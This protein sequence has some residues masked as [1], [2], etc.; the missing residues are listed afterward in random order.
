[1]KKY[2]EGQIIYNNTQNVTKLYYENIYTSA[3]KKDEAV[4]RNIVS[5]NC[6]SIANNP[7]KL[8]VYY[9]NPR[10]F[11][12]IAHNNMSWSDDKLLR[13]SVVYKYTCTTGDCTARNV[14]YVGYTTCKLFRR[15]TYH[16]QQGSI[17]DHHLQ[18]HNSSITREGIIENI[19]IIAH[20]SNSRKLEALKA[21]HI[22]EISP[23]NQYTV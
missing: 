8:I 3:Y 17:K 19:A 21:T 5:Q 13:S 9:R 14:C 4:I 1:M 11:N 7:M 10:S 23:S 2:V 6:Q 12:L 18:H 16:L 20:N 15:I 22:R